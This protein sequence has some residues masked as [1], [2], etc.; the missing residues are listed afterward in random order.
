MAAAVVGASAAV[1]CRED[2]TNLFPRHRGEL[3]TLCSVRTLHFIVASAGKE[4][5]VT[6]GT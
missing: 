4:W 6:N 3:H 5:W 1:E 2:E